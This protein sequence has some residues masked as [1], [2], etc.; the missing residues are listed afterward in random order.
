MAAATTKLGRALQ[1]RRTFVNARVKWVC[2]HHLDEA[3]QRE[4]NLKQVLSLKDRIVS[5]PPKSLPLSSLSLLKPLVNLH[6]TAAAF[7]Q[8]YPSVFSTHQPS[9]S[10]P[11]HVRLTPQALALHKEEEEM[12]H[13]SPLHRNATVQRLTKFLMLTGAGSLPLNVVDRFKFDLGLPHDYITSLIGDYPDFFEVTEI[14]DR[15]TGEP[16]LALA[17]SSRRSSLAVSEME[18]R[19]A[20]VDRSRVKKGLRIRY[21]MNFPKGYEL[22]KRVKEWVEQWQNLPYI[23][24]YENAFHLGSFSDQ[25]EKWAVAVLHELLH[26]LVSKKTET[27]NVLCLGEYLGFGIRFKQALVHH[28][29]IFYMSHKIRTQ[30]VVLREAYHKVFLIERHPLM[31]M[32]HRYLYLMSKSGRVKKRDY[33]PGIERSNQKKRAIKACED[34]EIYA[35]SSR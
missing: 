32:R 7:F 9:P 4:K 34:G 8:K 33:V 3:V 25:A 17:V 13:L 16:T 6:I 12:I 22:D 10:H 30:T 23:S 2:D 15:L 14:K 19:E 20:V 24:P 28:P 11:L 35:H 29:G 5:S 21:S 31:G 27:D 18:R 26:L 1:Q